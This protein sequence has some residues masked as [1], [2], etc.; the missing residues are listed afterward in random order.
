MADEVFPS[1]IPSSAVLA[2]DTYEME[3]ETFLDGTSSSGKRMF[4]VMSRVKA[5]DTYEGWPRFYN[6]V[7]GTDKAPLEIDPHA[8][9]VIDMQKFLAAMGITMAG[10]PI[11]VTIAG[12]IGKRYGE[13]TGQRVNKDRG[14][15]ENTTKRFFI[16]GA[17]PIG[18]GPLSNAKGS[19][20]APVAQRGP[21]VRNCAS[22]GKAIPA[23][24]FA[25]HAESCATGATA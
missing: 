5:P 23:A 6:F 11:G 16:L 19:A 1:N 7:A 22:C 20:S 2:E 8:R 18:Q 9:G 21:D 13:W 10:Q 25:A 4:S 3:C 15:L 14:E 17:Y 12:A 24:Q